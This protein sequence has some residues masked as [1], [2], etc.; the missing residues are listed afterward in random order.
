VITRDVGDEEA[1]IIAKIVY[2]RICVGTE[3]VLDRV[4]YALHEAETALRTGKVKPADLAE[5]E[6]LPTRRWACFAHMG[7]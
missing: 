4:P 5:N 1:A 6:R 2:E 3:L 7:A